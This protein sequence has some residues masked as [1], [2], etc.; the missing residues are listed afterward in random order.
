MQTIGSWASLQSHENFTLRDALAAALPVPK[1]WFECRPVL[2]YHRHRGRRLLGVAVIYRFGEYQIDTDIFELRRGAEVIKVEPQV[3]DLLIY[4]ISHRNR[5]VSQSELLDSIW[6]GKIVSLSTVASRI[7]AARSAIGDSG[8][9]QKLIRTIQRKGFRFVG[10]VSETAG[11]HGKCTSL[12]RREGRRP[13]DSFL[14][15]N[16]CRAHRL[17][18]GRQGPAGCEGRKLAQSSRI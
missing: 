7:N 1:L 13:G 5:V 3:F 4:L 14:H 16:R 6:S 2:D 18:P 11:R 12:C 10:E 15:H 17:C 8:A 9:A